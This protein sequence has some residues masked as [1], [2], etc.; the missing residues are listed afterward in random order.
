[1]TDETKMVGSTSGPIESLFDWVREKLGALFSRADAIEQQDDEPAYADGFQPDPTYRVQRPSL[2]AAAIRGALETLEGKLD[3]LTTQ[4]ENTQ[5]EADRLKREI[6]DLTAGI[7]AVTS[8]INQTGYAASTAEAMGNSL[9]AR[10]EEWDAVA[11]QAKELRAQVLELQAQV[12]AIEAQVKGT[13]DAIAERK[14]FYDPVDDEDIARLKEHMDDIERRLERAL[15]RG[16]E[17]E[18]DDLRYELND[19]IGGLTDDNR[20]RAEALLARLE[21]G[22]SAPEAA[23]PG[24]HSIYG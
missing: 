17:D 23:S 8:S 2:E 14:A 21:A 19:L 22:K 18:L 3:D 6:D 1:M 16:D 20:Y 10:T 7:R 5:A 13:E 24:A 9:A 12:Q 11:A 4:W 15:A